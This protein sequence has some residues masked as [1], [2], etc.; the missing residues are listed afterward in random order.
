MKRNLL[1]ALTVLLL[2]NAISAQS[3]FGKII[4]G[5]ESA[6]DVAQFSEGIKAKASPYL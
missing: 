6:F 5:V 4:V 2:C 3:S 1:S